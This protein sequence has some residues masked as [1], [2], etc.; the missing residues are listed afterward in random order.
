MSP[1]ALVL[2]RDNS[3]L[4]VTKRAGFLIRKGKAS[5]VR[6]NPTVI[7]LRLLKPDAE[8]IDTRHNKVES[9]YKISVYRVNGKSRLKLTNENITVRFL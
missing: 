7:R 5:L 8:R 4:G 9:S 2:N 6:K 3:Y 1:Y